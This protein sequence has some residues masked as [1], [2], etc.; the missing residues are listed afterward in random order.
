ME[1]TDKMPACCWKCFWLTQ[2]K[3]YFPPLLIAGDRYGTG[4]S[5]TLS[6]CHVNPKEEEIDRPDKYYCGHYKYDSAQ[7]K[8][9]AIPWYLLKKEELSPPSLKER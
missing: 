3:L 1:N 2:R 5:H 7:P 8:R 6:Y 9:A 4:A